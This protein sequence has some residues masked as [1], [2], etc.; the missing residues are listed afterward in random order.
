MPFLYNLRVTATFNV[1]PIHSVEAV[2][3]MQQHHHGKTNWKHPAKTKP[4][5][6]YK[7]LQKVDHL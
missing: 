6:V 1:I 4:R 3:R 5:K 2:Y 7:L